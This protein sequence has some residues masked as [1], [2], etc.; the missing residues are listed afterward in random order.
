MLSL[1]LPTVGVADHLSLTSGLRSYLLRLMQEHASLLEAANKK[2]V[3]WDGVLFID[4]LYV[5]AWLQE[6]IYII[7]E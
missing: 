1:P 7:R 4:I 5:S 6:Y 2:E 3:T